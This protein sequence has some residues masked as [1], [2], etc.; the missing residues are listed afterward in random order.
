VQIPGVTFVP[1]SVAN[2]NWI[3]RVA[4]TA[5]PDVVIYVAGSNSAA[6]AEE[7]P[8]TAEQMHTS[9]P[10]S[11]SAVAEI[12]QP[13]FIFLSSS[14]TFD[15]AKGNYKEQDIVLPST[16]LGKAKVG[17]ENFIRTKSLNHVI[18]RSAPVFGRG[19]GWNLSLLDRIRMELDRG[20]RFELPS[21][22]VHA[23]APVSGLVDLLCRLVDSGPRN[24][25]L[26]YG[27]LTKLS[28]QDFAVQFA[29]RFGYDP[30]LVLASRA[31]YG[32]GTTNILN[33]YDYSLNCS[34]VA[35]SLK[36]KPLLLE[37]G[38]DL[39]EKQLVA[40]L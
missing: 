26:H 40:A 6:R 25:T 37:E 29:K 32:Q 18:V 30:G 2:R 8:R 28:V 21:N 39:L 33:S 20:N 1:F 27:G 10:A 31:A 15:G 9:G 17:G 38:F 13:K 5:Q 36:I 7:D 11:V 19:N 23:F 4:Y 22:E 24:K 16:A 35:E 3:K 14:Y 34:Q 12:F